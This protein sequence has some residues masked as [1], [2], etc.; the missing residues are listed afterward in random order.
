MIA[1]AILS[2][3]PSLRESKVYYVLCSITEPVVSPVRDLIYRIPGADGL[4]F[5]LSFLAVYFLLSMI[6]NIVG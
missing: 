3:I 4:P 2:W 5:D 6:I 1:T